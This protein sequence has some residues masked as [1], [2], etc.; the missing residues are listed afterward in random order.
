MEI[1]GEE[2]CHGGGKKEGRGEGEG[3]GEREG[4]RRRGKE[5]RRKKEGGRRKEKGERGKKEKG[6]RR[7]KEKGER[8]KKEMNIYHIQKSTANRLGFREKIFLEN[9]GEF[10]FVI[11]KVLKYSFVQVNNEN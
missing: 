2:G 5:K 3:Q 7:R 6:G 8:G 1:G 9:E 4:D 10:C 11:M